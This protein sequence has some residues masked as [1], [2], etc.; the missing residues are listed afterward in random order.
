MLD[1][2]E[3]IIPA[4]KMC[5]VLVITTK[6]FQRTMSIKALR[7]IWNHPTVCVNALEVA[8]A[9]L[10]QWGLSGEGNKTMISHRKQRKRYF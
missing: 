8:F 5:I 6:M 9:Y 7:I 1:T 2:P 3:C 4:I 10:V